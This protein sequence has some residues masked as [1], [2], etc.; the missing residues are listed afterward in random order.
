M[1]E[2]TERKIVTS[3]P[4]VWFPMDVISASLTNL[5]WNWCIYPLGLARHFP[6][7]KGK[8][9]GPP[10]SLSNMENSSWKL[11]RANL[12]PILFKVI[13]LFTE[14]NAYPIASFRKDNQKLRRMQLLSLAYLQFGSRLPAFSLTAFA[15]SCPTFPDRTNVHL[16]SSLRQS[17]ALVAQAGVKWCDLGSPQPPPPGFKWFA[18][19]RRDSPV[20]VVSHCAQP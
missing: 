4:N 12:P 9:L 20:T 15:S 7:V 2:K 14:I 13:S 11:L 17:F 18:C 16:S 8:Y 1:K 19:H 6:I 10:K 5:Y 3:T